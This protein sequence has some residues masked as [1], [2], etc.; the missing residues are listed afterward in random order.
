MLDRLTARV[1][2]LVEFADAFG[3]RVRLLVADVGCIL[4]DGSCYPVT[5]SNDEE[6]SVAATLNL[7]ARDLDDILDGTLSPLTAFMTG[8]VTVDG[9]LGKA[10]QVSR[11][12]A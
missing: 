1:S 7:S 12:F 4:V 8:R 6:S 10:M 5:I 9:D 3:F 2:A 11:L